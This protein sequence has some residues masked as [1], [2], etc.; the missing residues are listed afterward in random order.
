MT[1]NPKRR[2][3]GTAKGQKMTLNPKMAEQRN[4]EKFPRM[5]IESPEILKD[6]MMENLPKS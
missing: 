1:P 5:P 3:R 6:G 4:G 2:K